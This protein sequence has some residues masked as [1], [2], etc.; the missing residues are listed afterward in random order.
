MVKIKEIPDSHEQLNGQIKSMSGE[1]RH[2]S[3]AR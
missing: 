3:E 1:D 2:V